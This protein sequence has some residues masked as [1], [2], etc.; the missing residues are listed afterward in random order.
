MR[1]L[2]STC[3]DMFVGDVH[4]RVPVSVMLS[5][6]YQQEDGEVYRK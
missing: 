3:V 1:L 6:F 2:L 5:G 4:S